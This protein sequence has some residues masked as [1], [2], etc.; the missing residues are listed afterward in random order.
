[1]LAP[2]RGTFLS[3][4]SCHL[5]PQRFQSTRAGRRPTLADVQDALQTLGVTLQM[6]TKE[7]KRRYRAL[8]KEHHPDAGGD[9]AIMT[10]ITVAYETLTQLSKRERDEFADLLRYSS[11]GAG[12]AAAAATSSRAGGTAAGRRTSSASSYRY[13]YATGGPSSSSS[14]SYYRSPGDA[15]ANG[16]DKTQ[17]ASSAEEAYH[18]QREQKEAF[19]SF[20]AR[21]SPM[22]NRR[23]T[24]GPWSGSSFSSASRDQ[25]SSYPNPFGGPGAFY[26]GMRPHQRARFMASRTLIM[27]GL[28]MYFLLLAVA[29]F[30][31][32]FW[33]DKRHEYE[34]RTSERMIR[35]ER[36]QEVHQLPFSVGSGGGGTMLSADERELLGKL[37]QRALWRVMRWKEEQREMAAKMGWPAVPEH[38]GTVRQYQVADERGHGR[39]GRGE[40][41]GAENPLISDLAAAT[42]SPSS[43]QAIPG[44]MVFEPTHPR[45]HLWSVEPENQHL[46]GATH[47]VPMTTGPHPHVRLSATTPPTTAISI[48]LEEEGEEA[49]QG[50]E[51]EQE[52]A[53]G[54]GGNTRS[55][56]RMV[57]AVWS[58]VRFG[59]AGG[60]G[61]GSG[62]GSGKR[63]EKDTLE[64]A[65][66]QDNDIA[67]EK[68][69]VQN[70]FGLPSAGTSSS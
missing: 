35:N 33:R 25:Y 47:N 53:S 20:Y 63:N 28:A 49:E 62:S 6:D 39:V 46:P 42:A 11:S 22:G 32:R 70:L 41:G 7:W 36:L 38:Y 18:H 54:S 27:R 14:S 59:H 24:K 21:R 13:A 10:R 15:S 61:A 29:M 8:A 17:S 60:T 44:V 68:S 52:K 50:R 5:T 40:G 31:Y 16:N 30:V 2:R 69:V 57:Q 58:R 48:T 51:K 34:W 19:W 67:P 56:T 9:P 43:R 64:E 3:S 23:T 12:M 26:F 4:L 55:A 45:H 1:M 65:S 66:H 37:D